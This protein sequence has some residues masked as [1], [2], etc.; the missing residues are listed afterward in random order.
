MV[1]RR[2]VM[3]SSSPDFPRGTDL[4]NTPLLN[5]GTAFT[6]EERT[7]FGKGFCRHTFSLRAEISWRKTL[8]PNRM[9]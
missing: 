8:G 7:R 6:E 3:Q 9:T 1:T 5:K 2:Q 4:L